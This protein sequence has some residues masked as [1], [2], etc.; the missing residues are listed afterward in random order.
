MRNELL[1]TT[2]QGYIAGTI[3]TVE[4]FDGAFVQMMV[5]PADVAAVSDQ[6]RGDDRT[7]SVD[8]G[9]RGSR[10][11]HRLGDQHLVG[12]DLPVQ[13]F[14]CR[15]D[16]FWSWSGAAHQWGRGFLYPGASELP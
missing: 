8:V 7:D 11:G 12:F 10:S 15:P 5:E 1:Y 3:D 13:S 14:G 4:L 9:H 16:G 6:E 2:E